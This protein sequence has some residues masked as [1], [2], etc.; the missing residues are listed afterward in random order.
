MPAAPA[1]ARPH[2][3]THFRARDTPEP[4]PRCRLCSGFPQ[5]DRRSVGRRPPGSHRPAER[6]RSRS[7]SAR[8]AAQSAAAGVRKQPSRHFRPPKRSE[9]QR[10]G[11][12]RESSHP[13]RPEMTSANHVARAPPS[14][15]GPTGQDPS[16][17]CACAQTPGASELGTRS[18]FSSSWTD[19][20]QSLVFP[21]CP[22]DSCGRTGK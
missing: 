5:R 7:P 20:T 12:H 13:R 18:L 16:C 9:P 17:S 22:C 6:R 15:S 10:R 19:R 8:A 21:R 14:E 1:L 2:S 3:A 4:Y 11:A